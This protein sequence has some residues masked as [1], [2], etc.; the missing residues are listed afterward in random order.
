MNKVRSRSFV[1]RIIDSIEYGHMGSITW[2]VESVD[3]DIY[4]KVRTSGENIEYIHDILESVLVP[5]GYHIM[6]DVHIPPNI[7]VYEI[8]HYERSKIDSLLIDF[9][10]AML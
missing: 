7:Y 2:F 8:T 5:E 6:Y 9:K 4:F 3:R 10:K 1:N